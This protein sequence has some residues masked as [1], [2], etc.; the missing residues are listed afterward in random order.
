MRPA[1]ASGQDDSFGPRMAGQQGRSL[2]EC[3]MEAHIATG[4]ASDPMAS[5]E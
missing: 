4:M 2:L 5:R 1:V 3:F